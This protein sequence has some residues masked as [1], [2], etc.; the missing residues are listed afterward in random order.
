MII[1]RSGARNILAMMGSIDVS[2][3]NTRDKR[4]LFAELLTTADEG[5][6]AIMM[7]NCPANNPVECIKVIRGFTGLGLKEA[8]DLLDS[9][10]PHRLGGTIGPIP[11]STS[12]DEAVQN[13]SNNA[14]VRPFTTSIVLDPA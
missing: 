14:R 6:D 1:S 13:L 7:K 3:L 12:F 5:A 10:D 11:I 8:K 2:T 4:A 9:L